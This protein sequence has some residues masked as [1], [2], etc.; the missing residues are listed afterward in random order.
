[1]PSGNTAHAQDLLGKSHEELVLLLI[2]VRRQSAALGEAAD[3]ARAEL[4]RNPGAPE[5]RSVLTKEL[6]SFL[7]MYRV[8]I[9]V[10]SNLPLTPKQRLRF[11][12]R[13][14]Y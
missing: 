8:T 5:I 6:L 13:P 10:D 1:M 9:Q 3:V 4:E 11:S 7:N 12:K 2:H 14:M